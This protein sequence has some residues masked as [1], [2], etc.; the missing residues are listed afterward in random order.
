MLSASGAVWLMG[1]VGPPDR[2]RC[3]TSNQVAVCGAPDANNLVAGRP[4]VGAS[5]N[6]LQCAHRDLRFHLPAHV[7]LGN[8][9]QR[10]ASARRG[11]SGA[12]GALHCAFRSE[13]LL[14]SGLGRRTAWASA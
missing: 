2:K 4:L 10:P 7:L 14:Y 11:R 12:D 6:P 13:P 9:Y 8:H 5:S 1:A 3:E